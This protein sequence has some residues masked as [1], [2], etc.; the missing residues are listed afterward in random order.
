MRRGTLILLF[1]N[2]VTGLLGREGRCKTKIEAEIAAF[3]DYDI[4]T[5]KN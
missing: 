3:L 5:G 2:Y 4:K 1:C